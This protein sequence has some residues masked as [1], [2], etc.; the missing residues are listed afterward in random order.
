MSAT[1]TTVHGLSLYALGDVQDMDDVNRD[2]GIIEQGLQKID[3]HIDNNDNPH[4]VTKSDV[5]LGSVDNTSDANKPIS[6]AQ[7]A[8]NATTTAHISSTSNPHGVTKAQLGLS[9]VNNTAD[10]NKPV[11]TAQQAAINAMGALKVDKTSIVNNLTTGGTDKVLSA[12]QGKELKAEVDKKVTGVDGKDLSTNDFTNAYKAQLDGLN[13]SLSAKADQPYQQHTQT[14]GGFHVE[15]SAGGLVADALISG[16]TVQ[17]GTPTPD[18]PITPLC[19]PAGTEIKAISENWFDPSGYSSLYN[20]ATGYFEATALVFYNTRFNVPEYLQHTQFTFSAYVKGAATNIRVSIV[21]TDA[22][23]TNGNNVNSVNEF[24][25]T[26][27]TS[28]PE[29]TIS[30]ICIGYG[31]GG[32]FTTYAKDVQINLGSIATLYKPYT[33]PATF[34]TPCD[35]MKVNAADSLNRVTG[36]ATQKV[37][38]KVFDGTENW[39]LQGTNS[40]N[41]ISFTLR[42]SNTEISPTTVAVPAISAH[43]VYTESALSA[44]TTQHIYVQRTTSTTT[45]YVRM[46][47]DTMPDVASFKAWLVA[48]YAAGTPVTVWYELATPIETQSP[49]QSITFP[50]GPVN[51]L[52]I[53]PEGTGA[54]PSKMSMTYRQDLQAFIKSITDAIY[55]T[56]AT[57]I[58]NLTTRVAELEMAA[59]GD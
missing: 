25:R 58:T 48:Q 11:S 49:P 27:V 57:N 24:V 4:G 28:N 29:K 47:L 26:M 34:T 22:T 32:T 39:L 44:A 20:P 9:N 55:D 53:F 50:K 7:S 56:L 15:D 45:A 51:V 59:G 36:V 33:N 6:D 19:L 16:N 52:V 21:Y 1:N 23:V 41:I 2:N 46:Y 14:D 5:G 3:D 10:V 38:K 40:N 8:V 37:Y 43:F 42:L 18:A 17:N 12:E 35:L 54:L 30:Y 13:E 31:S